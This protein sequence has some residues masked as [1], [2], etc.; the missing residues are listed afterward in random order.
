MKEILGENGTIGT[1]ATTTRFREGKPELYKVLHAALNEAMQIIASDKGRAVDGYV[2]ATGDRKR[3]ATCIEIA[4]DPD[5]EFT[6]TPRAMQTY[7]DFM[8]RVGTVKRLPDK[9]ADLFFSETAA[10]NGS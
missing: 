4:N 2:G 9:W 3:R 7:A 10:L 8:F 6:M 1:A 5:V